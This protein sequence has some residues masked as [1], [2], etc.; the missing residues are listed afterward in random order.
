M[1]EEIIK[2][3]GNIELSGFREIE[4]INNVVINKI[5]GSYA[6][7]FSE[8]S[9]NFEKL[10]INLKTI[11]DTG[12]SRKIE[13]HAKASDNGKVFASEVVDRNLYFALDTVLKK[14]KAEMEK[15]K[16]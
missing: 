10:Q 3:G 15:S 14:V 2:L 1:D 12:N 7:K 4:R 8:I 13:I 16:R 9:T 6:R 11:H 5:V